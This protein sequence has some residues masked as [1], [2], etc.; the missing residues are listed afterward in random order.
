MYIWRVKTKKTTKGG[1]GGIRYDDAP[2]APGILRDAALAFPIE[3]E[4]MVRTQI[5]L[6]RVEHEFVQREAGRRNVPMA[7]VIRQFID[8][9]ME[10]PDNAWI[11]NPMLAPSAEDPTWEGQED[12]AIN[13]DHYVYG[14]PKR[15]VKS[16]GK[17]IESPRLLEDHDVSR[18]TASA[19]RSEKSK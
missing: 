18:R 11:N 4:A 17:W 1:S 3:D 5:Y 15:F 2:S 9:K 13:H 6:S 7:A 12:A 16:H 19:S 14:T 10:A 8:D